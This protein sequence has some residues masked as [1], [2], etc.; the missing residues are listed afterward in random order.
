VPLRAFIAER[1]EAQGI[2]VVG[3]GDGD[4]AL[5]TIAEEQPDCVI[6]D[7]ML[8]GKN[9]MEILAEF[10]GIDAKTPVVVLTTLSGEGGL[11]DEATKRDAIFLNKAEASI[12]EVLDTV[13]SAMNM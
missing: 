10:R 1:L 2:K 13:L 4:K 12:E 3:C 5:E 7:M 6:L 9:G 8:P 11:E